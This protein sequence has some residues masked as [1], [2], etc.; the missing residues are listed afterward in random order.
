[1]QQR[2]SLITLGVAS[3]ERAVTFYGRLGWQV[4]NDWR[5]QQVAFFQAGGMVFGLWSQAELAT[6]SGTDPAARPGAVTLACNT[7]AREEVDVVLDEAR[8][9]GA[10]IVREGAETDWGGYSGAF[11]DPDGHAWEVA[12]NPAWRM[13][14]DGAIVLPEPH[15]TTSTDV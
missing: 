6:D 14:A 3:L 2:I 11:H 5:A 12:H 7:H 13:D 15:D 9:A 10:T 1:M 8:A 4:A